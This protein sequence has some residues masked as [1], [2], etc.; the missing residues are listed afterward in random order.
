M[1]GGL[2]IKLAIPFRTKRKQEG[3]EG[4]PFIKR[5]YVRYGSKDGPQCWCL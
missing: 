3:G 4:M 5:E 2:P 1:S